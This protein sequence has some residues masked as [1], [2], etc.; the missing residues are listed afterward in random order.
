M[1]MGKYTWTNKQRR[2]SRE[3]VARTADLFAA[4]ALD[5]KGISNVKVVGLEFSRELVPYLQSGKV[6]IST[7]FSI[8]EEG[9]VI[10]EQPQFF[11]CK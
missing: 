6:D 2:I 11:A 5:E 3:N 10:I 9:I 7:Y 8:I 1:G 4:M